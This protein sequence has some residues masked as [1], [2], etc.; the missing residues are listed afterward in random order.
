MPRRWLQNSA[1]AFNPGNPQNEC[2]PFRTVER[3]SRV[4]LEGIA[5]LLK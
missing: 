2:S 5:V 3:S 4:I 1:Q